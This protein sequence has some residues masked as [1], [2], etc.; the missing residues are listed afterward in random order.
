[1]IGYI[2]VGVI[3]LAAG[4]FGGSFIARGLAKKDL[5]ALKDHVTAKV[6]EIKTALHVTPPSDAAK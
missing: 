1:M 4:G 3:C 6:G 5:A 2:V